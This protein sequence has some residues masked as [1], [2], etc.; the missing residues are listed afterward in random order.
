MPLLNYDAYEKAVYEWL[1]AK[2]EADHTFCFSTRLRA[3]KGSEHKYFIGT[4]RSA[5][6]GT[7]FWW[8]PVSFPGSS[9]DLINLIFRFNNGTYQC[10]MQFGQTRAPHDEQNRE[11]LLFI[12]N[13]KEVFKKNGINFWENGPN[14]KMEYYNTVLADGSTDISSF[15][16]EVDE[17][18]FAMIHLV[19]GYLNE[20]KATSTIEANRIDEKLFVGKFQKSLNNRLIKLTNSPV[21]DQ[22]SASNYKETSY[23]PHI[24][25]FP[26][27]QILYGPP[28]T[29]K[30]YHTINTALEILGED[31]KGSSR[32]EI[33]E[34][35]EQYLDEKRI[36]FTTFHQSIAYE[37]FI[38][39]IKPLKPDASGNVKYDVVDGIFKELTTVARSN[40]ENSQIVNS[41]KLSFEEAFDK[42]QQEW[43]INPEIKFAVKT[44]GY[45]YTVIG[46]TNTSIQFKKASGGTSHTLSINT[47]R[48]IYY[49]KFYSFKQGVGIYY[50]GILDKL[51]SYDRGVETVEL[52]NYVLIIDEINRGNVSQIFGELITLIEENKREGMPEVLSVTLPYSKDKFSVPLNL[53]IIGTMNTADRSVESLDTALRRRFSFK[54]MMPDYELLRGNDY[55]WNQLIEFHEEYDAIEWPDWEKNYFD[56]ATNFYKSL[57]LEITVNSSEEHEL[58]DI[59]Q[60]IGFKKENLMP[61]LSK[62]TFKK[63]FDLAGLLEV[64]NKRIIILYD[65]EHQIGHSYFLKI[66]NR[67]NP[68]PELKHCFQNEIIP[69]LQEYFFGDYEKIG[70]VLG[71]GF[72]TKTAPGNNVFAKFKG[73]N[74]SDF[75]R[76]VYEINRVV[77]ASDEA[78][79]SALDKLIGNAVKLDNLAQEV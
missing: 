20:F 54:E 77:F 9:S 23:E 78:F 32:E 60:S 10:Y 66:R 57:G 65:R 47:L 73:S 69:L 43:E 6:F 76:P 45:E 22:S 61:Q 26:P 31:I 67:I 37:D 35:F 12:K 41:E 79:E 52:Q 59:I 3:S 18:L 27:N 5:Y 63:M 58:Y 39:G 21:I 40:Y 49:G 16:L 7:T 50:P 36:V 34:L 17:K 56:L 72:V 14:N 75:D 64:I 55:I 71:E 15:L 33:K 70:L 68:F 28:G 30:T 1:L 62:F 25:L 46:F 51:N 11:A 44:P 13:L 48:E 8:I 2:H 38:E 29:G 74:P 24:F 53:Y 4:R 19:D 42:L